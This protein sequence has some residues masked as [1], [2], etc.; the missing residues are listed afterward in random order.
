MKIKERSRLHPRPTEP[1]RPICTPQLPSSHT[2]ALD[3]FHT[4]EVQ[5]SIPCSPTIN[6]IKSIT[7]LTVSRRPCP[8]NL[9]VQPGHRRQ[10]MRDLI[11]RCLPSTRA[12][13]CHQ[14]SCY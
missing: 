9:G 14:C 1:I 2:C 3:F 6:T 5:G 12:N 7:Y 8:E 4:G 11:A 13:E 10:L